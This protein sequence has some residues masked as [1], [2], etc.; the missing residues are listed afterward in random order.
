MGIGRV[1]I[2]RPS[3]AVLRVFDPAGLQLHDQMLNEC[4]DARRHNRHPIEVVDKG[5]VDRRGRRSTLSVRPYAE[6]YPVN[7]EHREQF[8]VLDRSRPVRDGLDP[9]SIGG[10]I[11]ADCAVQGVETKVGPQKCSIPPILPFIQTST[12]L[13]QEAS[14]ALLDSTEIRSTNGT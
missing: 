10:L 2:P 14:K 1:R 8:D 4:G 12:L 11:D 7:V 6:Q 9:S 13:W 3:H 5:N